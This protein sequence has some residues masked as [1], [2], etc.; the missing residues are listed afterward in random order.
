MD[1]VAEYEQA[2]RAHLQWCRRCQQPCGGHQGF[3]KDT[4]WSFPLS[5]PPPCGC[6][7][8][9]L[10]LFMALPQSL[11]LKNEW[12]FNED[13]QSRR[14]PLKKENENASGNAMRMENQ[15]RK[16]TIVTCDKQHEGKQE[17]VHV[18]CVSGKP[19]RMGTQ[20][21]T[22]SIVTWNKQ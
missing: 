20:K 7:D 2:A 18:F 19:T 22:T 3:R 1:E 14:K 16:T 12:P 4:F 17:I 10:S 8:A 11:P 15:K 9:F 13:H 21:R 6:C 5:P